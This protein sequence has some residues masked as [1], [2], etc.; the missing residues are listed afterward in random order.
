MCLYFKLL[1]D[2][3]YFWDDVAA[4]EVTIESSFEEA[5]NEV[6][7]LV[8]QDLKT[9]KRITVVHADGSRIIVFYPFLITNHMAS[10]GC[11][12]EIRTSREEQD[13]NLICEKE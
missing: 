5:V 12:L 7:A 9:T 4:I 1:I 10:K 8:K 2:G 11:Y 6:Y 3:E 13:D